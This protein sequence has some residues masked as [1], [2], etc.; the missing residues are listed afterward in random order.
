MGQRGDGANKMRDNYSS[1]CGVYN[2]QK[3]EILE[4]HGAG[5]N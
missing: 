4:N 1:G 2:G 5:T 3:F